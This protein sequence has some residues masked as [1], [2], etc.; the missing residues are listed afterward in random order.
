MADL[1][2]EDVRLRQACAVAASHYASHWRHALGPPIRAAPALARLTH[3]HSLSQGLRRGAWSSLFTVSDPGG[4]VG[5]LSDDLS[6]RPRSRPVGPRAAI[7]VPRRQ[8][9]TV[10]TTSSE[11]SNRRPASRW[12]SLHVILRSPDEPAVTPSARHDQPCR[13]RAR[14]RVSRWTGQR[15]RRLRRVRK[16]VPA[17]HVPHRS[18]RPDS[19]HADR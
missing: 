7:Q 17:D 10:P 2:I 13:A 16:P 4:L 12:Q 9:G 15:L 18:R 11:S 14:A 8:C 5:R 19:L 1:P 6:E 3:A